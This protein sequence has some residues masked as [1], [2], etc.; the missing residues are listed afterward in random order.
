MSKGEKRNIAVDFD[1]VIHRYSR[2]WQG[3]DIYDPPMPSADEGLRHLAKH[4]NVIV[5][6]VRRPRL[7]RPWLAHHNLLRYVHEVTNEKPKAVLYIDDRAYRFTTWA[8]A[9]DD[10]YPTKIEGGYR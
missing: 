8:K 1:G 3:D 5:F 6:T 7:V 4:W 9:I 10:C 2:G